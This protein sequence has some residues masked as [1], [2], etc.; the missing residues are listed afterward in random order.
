VQAWKAPGAR[1]A[2]VA[3]VCARRRRRREAASD[4]NAAL[5]EYRQYL[6]RAAAAAEMRAAAEA[7]GSGPGAAGAAAAGGPGAGSS[8]SL[9]PGETLMLRAVKVG[10]ANFLSTPLR[11]CSVRWACLRRAATCA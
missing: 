11:V 2:E 3:E 10:T 4:F 9:K 1:A 5:A 8:Y 6:L 7:A